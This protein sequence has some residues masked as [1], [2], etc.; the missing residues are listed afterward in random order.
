MCARLNSHIP[1]PHYQ[2][3]KESDASKTALRD[4]EASLQAALT[5]L[6]ICVDEGKRLKHQCQLLECANAHNR[7]QSRM[8]ASQTSATAAA[9]A[10]LISGERDQEQ[11]GRAHV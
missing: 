4:K 6:G 7:L 1:S 2:A 10:A 5:K 8:G 3:R 9:N 11:I